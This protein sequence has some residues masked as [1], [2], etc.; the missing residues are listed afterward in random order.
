M[1]KKGLK[2]DWI[3]PTNS[4][5]KGE[6]EHVARIPETP[7]TDETISEENDKKKKKRYKKYDSGLSVTT[8]KYKRKRKR[9]N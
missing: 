3:N 1:E 5:I 7:E 2:K 6:V 4:Q 9:N 8:G